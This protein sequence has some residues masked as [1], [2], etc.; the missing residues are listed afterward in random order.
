MLA[1]LN[2]GRD[3]VACRGSA[4]WPLKALSQ[5]QDAWLCLQICLLQSLVLSW[6]ASCPSGSC[7]ECTSGV[8]RLCAEGCLST[9][10]FASHHHE[11]QEADRGSNWDLHLIT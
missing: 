7:A 2:V 8:L 11:R 1:V 9:M 4:E 3:Y 5:H 10:P 6:R